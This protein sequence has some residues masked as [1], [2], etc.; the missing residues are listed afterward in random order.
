MPQ[1][2]DDVIASLRGERSENVGVPA[3]CADDVLGWNSSGDQRI[4]NQRAMA[5]P[6]N[7]FRAHQRDPL[8]F[9]KLDE[10]FQTLPKFW[11]LHVVGIAAER[12][13]FPTRID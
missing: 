4:G 7:S 13:V 5:A 12:G 6:G 10:V 2:I 11:R 1:R 8:F 9:R 3:S